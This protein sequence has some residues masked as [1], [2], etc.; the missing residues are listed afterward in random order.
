MQ[1]ESLAALES[2][3]RKLQGTTSVCVCVLPL[4]LPPHARTA[5]AEAYG[6]LSQ[7]GLVRHVNLRPL[8][9]RQL[10]TFIAGA[11]EAT[12]EPVALTRLWKQTR[13]WPA[14]AGTVIESFHECGLARIVDRRAYL[15]RGFP[16][17]WPNTDLPV[18]W[19]R[20]MGPEY[21]RAAKAI[22]VVGPLGEA[23][24]RLVAEAMGIP[25]GEAI[26]LLT[27]LDRAGVLKLHRA[28][29]AWRFRLPLVASCLEELLGPYERRK[30]AQIAVSA[31]WQGT[32]RCADPYYLPDQ[33]VNAGAMVDKNRARN[34]LLTSA[35]RVA[36]RGS[37]RAI[38]WLRA[39]AELTGDRVDR[40]GILL[41]HAWTCL[42]RGE[43]ALALE[44]SDTVLK[45]YAREI[46]D[47]MVPDVLFVHLT[48]M[49][50]AGETC[51][52]EKIA[53]GEWWPWPGTALEQAVARAYTLSLLGRWQETLAL[54]S[55]ETTPA[56]HDVET[57]RATAE[58]W[59]GGTAGFDRLVAV[60]PGRFKAGESPCQEV[61]D[62]AGALLVLA[63]RDRA[64]RL[65]AGVHGSPVQLDLPGQSLLAVYHGRIDEALDLAHKSIATSA[66][67]GCNHVQTAMYQIAAVLQLFRGRLARA[68]DLIATARTRQPTLPH[69]L[70]LAE[71]RYGLVFGEIESAESILTSALERAEENGVLARTEGLWIMLADIALHT[72]RTEDLP[73]Y[74]R[75]VDHVATR[76][77]TEL[78]EIDRLTLRALVESDH[79]SAQAAIRLAERRGQPLEQFVVLQRLVRY[80]VAEPGLLA[81]AYALLG[82]MNA[83]LSRASTRNLM[84]V[85]GVAIPGRQEAVAENERLLAVLVTEGLSNKQIANALGSSEKSVEGRLSRL[86]SRTGYQSRVELATA[87]LTGQFH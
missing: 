38:P 40:V 68:R 39:A 7:D 57:I 45:S 73:G 26:R 30:L 85:H 80:G 31:L 4:P 63:E 25:E 43:A 10:D 48:A 33:L 34:E 84:R 78:A 87:M 9:P 35:G 36:V 1:P 23:A 44:S 60:L 15:R 56:T 86:F 37:V 67:H 76:M 13:G 20:R 59:L 42:V 82:D 64:E 11:I 28:E 46:P 17:R 47:G 5:F 52:L 65:A 16:R 83:L 49:H 72:G 81:E 21:W 58:L 27:Q 18:Q 3:V 77:G 6:R 75:K 32:A 70:A 53:Q 69:L 29:R 12:L 24:P 41:T 8:S 19:I 71:A 14:T 61:S 79:A 55:P 2:L 66:P 51:T 50:Q 62:R 74:L 54:L 22:A